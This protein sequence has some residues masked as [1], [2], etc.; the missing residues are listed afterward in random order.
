MPMEFRRMARNITIGTMDMVS[1][2]SDMVDHALIGIDQN[3]AAVCRP[4]VKELLAM[5]LKAEELI[6]FWSST[7]SAI[8]FKEGDTVRKF[9]VALLARIEMEPYLTGKLP[10][11]RSF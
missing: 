8:Y 4:F 3:D 7:P 10:Q 5:N 11:G 1:S 6:Q 2:I 9:L